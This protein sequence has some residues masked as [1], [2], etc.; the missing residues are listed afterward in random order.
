MLRKVKAF[1]GANGFIQHGFARA[2]G[3]ENPVLFRFFCC[4][5]G[6]LFHTPP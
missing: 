3:L 6:L 1:D 4:R 5:S 2:Q